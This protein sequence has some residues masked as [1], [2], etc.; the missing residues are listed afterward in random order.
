MIIIYYYYEGSAIIKV[1][2]IILKE[3]AVI[4]FDYSLLLL[5]GILYRKIDKDILKLSLRTKYG[6]GYVN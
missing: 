2:V 3:K 6:L 1:I 5:I 4:N